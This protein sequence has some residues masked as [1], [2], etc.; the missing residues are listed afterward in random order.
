MERVVLH[1]GIFCVN[2]CRLIDSL[3]WHGVNWAI[4]EYRSHQYLHWRHLCAC[5]YLIFRMVV[6]KTPLHAATGKC[7]FP[8]LS[9]EETLQQ[10]VYYDRCVSDKLAVGR[11][12]NIPHIGMGY[13]Y[14]HITILFLLS[15]PQARRSGR[16][17]ATGRFLPYGWRNRNR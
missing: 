10:S 12:L 4:M 8:A 13:R 3:R 11:I 5:H 2:S 17:E 15:L 1:G 7:I 6:E 9:K 14:R 16:M